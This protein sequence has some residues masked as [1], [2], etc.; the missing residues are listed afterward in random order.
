MSIS[1]VRQ[2]IA[3][4]LADIKEREKALQ[5]ALDAL[6]KVSNGSAPSRGRARATTAS[7]TARRGRRGPRTGPT[8]AEK[9]IDFI[10]ANPKE[11]TRSGIASGTGI[12][13]NTVSTTLNKLK[14][15]GK[16]TAKD[17]SYSAK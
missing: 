1:S 2:E 9:I 7:S 13:A 14:R 4:E 5:A 6:D 11:A 8:N 10:K 12:G 16:V 15:E 3:R 17:G